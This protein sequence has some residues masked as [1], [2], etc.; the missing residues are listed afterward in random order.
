MDFDPLPASILLQLPTFGA[1]QVIALTCA[2][3][4]LLVSGFVSGSEIS[5][6]SLDPD[7]ERLDDISQGQAIKR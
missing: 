6:F 4:A 1:A 2:L 3:L 5:F 7:D